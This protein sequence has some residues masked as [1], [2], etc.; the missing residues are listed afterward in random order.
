MSGG[1]EEWSLGEFSSWRNL[2]DGEGKVA[3]GGG[4]C[5]PPRK[6][7]SNALEEDIPSLFSGG[8]L[9]RCGISGQ[10]QI[11]EGETRSV[12]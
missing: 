12:A 10:P 6:D 5:W 11:P 3:F 8:K 7:K 2:S 9:C 1:G 4:F